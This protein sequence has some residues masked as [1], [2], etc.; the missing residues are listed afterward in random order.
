MEKEPSAPAAGGRGEGLV[1]ALRELLE[2][3]DRRIQASAFF[4]A[5]GASVVLHG[6]V[7]KLNRAD[8]PEHVLAGYGLFTIGAALGFLTLSGCD[9]LGRAAA[10]VEELLRGFFQ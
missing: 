8:N 1:V 6:T 3:K 9:R 4:F 2:L 5:C 10:R 7:L